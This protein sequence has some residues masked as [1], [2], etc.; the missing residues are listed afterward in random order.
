MTNTKPHAGVLIAIMV[1]VA[2][3]VGAAHY[4]T[5]S[6]GAL[7]FD[8]DEYLTDNPR[9]QNPSWGSA[10]R[11]LAE[12]LAP[13]TVRGYYQPLSMISLMADAGLGGTPDNLRSFHRTSLLLHVANTLLVVLLVYSLFG[14]PWAAGVVGLIFGMHPMTVEPIAWVGDRKTVLSAFFA[15]IS[16][17]LYVRYARTCTV[18]VGLCPSL[19]NTGGQAASGTSRSLLVRYVLC[20]A[21]FV[22]ALMSKPTTTLLP[23]M[24]LIMDFWPLQ[25]IGRRAILEKLPL[26]AVA[27]VFAVITVVSQARTAAV[28]LPQA[29]SGGSIL[30]GFCHNLIFY[31]AKMLWPAGLSSYYAHPEPMSPVNPMILV[32]LVGSV[33]LIAALVVSLRWTRALLASGLMFVAVIL[34]TMSG[35]GFTNVIASDKYA[36]LPAVGLAIGLAWLLVRFWAWSATHG[37]RVL[38]RASLCAVLVGAMLAEAAVTHRQAGRWDDT[39]NYYQYMVALSPGTKSTYRLHNNLGDA[40]MKRGRLP[41]AVE[42]FEAALRLNPNDH[43]VQFNAGFTAAQQKRVGDAVRHYE[44]ALQLAP[45]YADSHF[46]LANALVVLK[47]L[48]QAEEHYR[49]AVEIDPGRAVARAHLANLLTMLGKAEEALAEYQRALELDP[50]VP[51]THKSFADLLYHVGRKAEAVSHYR[52]ALEIDP[53]YP[54]ACNNLAGVFTVEGGQDAEALELYA[55]ALRNDPDYV[56]ARENMADLLIKLGRTAEAVAEYGKILEKQPQNERVQAKMAAASQPG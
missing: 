35:I 13:T 10:G 1:A 55:R 39:I 2:G 12:V 5:L 34:P 38:L 27:A 30:L 52:R 3:L 48:P 18:P 42:Q 31:P 4:R 9:V 33:V 23:A 22:L 41:E 40:L 7:I 49:K 37:Q 17:N 11:F 16:L 51:E 24:M 54:Q 46:Q 45:D 44:A 19:Q 29:G 50:S 53:N 20:L 28:G 36:Y 47:R 21:A 56:M 43:V 26:F 25:R 8:D 15:L 6:T 14:M 32:G